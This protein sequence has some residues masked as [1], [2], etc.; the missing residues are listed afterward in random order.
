MRHNEE[1]GDWWLTRGGA[2]SWSAYSACSSA[3]SADSSTPLSCSSAVSLSSPEGQGQRSCLW[4]YST[5]SLAVIN[6]IKTS[7][8]PIHYIRCHFSIHN[9]RTFLFKVF[10]KVFLAV[11][12][13]LKKFSSWDTK[14][15]PLLTYFKSYEYAFIPYFLPP[16]VIVFFIINTNQEVNFKKSPDN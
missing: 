5:V 3:W 13:K 10:G 7:F 14:S 2:S 11:E 12:H 6:E 4:V 1:L 8:Y 16:R 9:Q 15:P